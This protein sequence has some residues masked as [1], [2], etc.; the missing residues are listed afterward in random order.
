MSSSSSP[1]PKP[2]PGLGPRG[3]AFW[4][5][6][7]A[8]LELESHEIRLLEESCRTLDR[9]EA[10]DAVIRRQGLLTP[11]GKAHP[12]LVEARLQGVTLARLIASLR[13][14]DEYRAEILDRGQRRGSARGTYKLKVV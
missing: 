8:D 4:R 12:A 2:P 5:A 9:L 10:L 14:P 6:V 7:L 13:L 11:D 1:I 3:R